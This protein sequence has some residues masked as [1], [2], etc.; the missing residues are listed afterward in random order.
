[1]ADVQLL[2]L[3]DGR[4]MVDVLVGEPV[5]GMYRET[6]PSGEPGRGAQALDLVSALSVARVRELPRVK[7]DR[8]RTQLCRDA[9]HVLVRVDEE[10]RADP[11]RAQP[12]ECGPRAFS[13]AFVQ[14]SE[15][16]LCRDL[17]T[18]LRY[19]RHLHRIPPARQLQH[20]G[21]GG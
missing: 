2:D 20:V 21:I 1:V 19:Q 8:I 16:S 3:R 6:Q 9:D 14:E 17:F 13:H 12:F 5:P 10:R 11:L 18:L 15:A 7:L 4:D